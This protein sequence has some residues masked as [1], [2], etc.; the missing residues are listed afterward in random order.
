[1]PT[2][3]SH[4]ALDLSGKW[5]VVE[6]PTLPYADSEMPD[7]K[8]SCRAESEP[9]IRAVHERGTPIQSPKTGVSGNRQTIPGPGREDRLQQAGRSVRGIAGPLLLQSR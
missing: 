7:L 9:A 5:A 4:P 2:I 1:M 8:A 6:L 3:P